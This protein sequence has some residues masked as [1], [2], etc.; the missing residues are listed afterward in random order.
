MYPEEG[1]MLVWPSYL[2]H[3]SYPYDGKNDRII[4]SA[5]ARVSVMQ[6]GKAIRSI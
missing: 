6:D 5:N 1:K 4:I 2:M 3:G